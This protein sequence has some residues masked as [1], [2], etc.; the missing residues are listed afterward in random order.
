[1]KKSFQTLITSVLL[2][3]Y[4]I[5][6]LGIGVHECS[7]NGSINIRLFAYSR[8]CNAIH[9]VCNC[10]HHHHDGIPEHQHH[11]SNCCHTTIYQ[12]SQDYDIVSFNNAAVSASI[13]SNSHVYIIS[14]FEDS[15]IN[16]SSALFCE[17]AYTPPPLPIDINP[18]S[19][20]S[21]WRL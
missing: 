5:A 17:S 4:V 7:R 8:S 19:F 6:S 12:L 21:Q 9:P 18:Y 16:N 14:N 10:F 20:C 2:S 13:D 1:M 15:A 3:F 11:S